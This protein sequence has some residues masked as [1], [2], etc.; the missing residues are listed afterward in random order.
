MYCLGRILVP[1]LLLLLLLLGHSRASPLDL[2]S[3][4]YAD[5]PSGELFAHLQRLIDAEQRHGGDG[6]PDAFAAVLAEN[7]YYVHHGR[8]TCHGRAQVVACLLRERHEL[9]SE[10][11]LSQQTTTLAYRGVHTAR[12][13]TD[14]RRGADQPTRYL[15]VYYTYLTEP[16]GTNSGP[17]QIALLERVA[18]TR[19]PINV[20]SLLEQ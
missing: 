1:T 9:A 11:R 2:V 7:C 18:T 15:D 16:G 17:A 14:V 5:A 8:G 20:E 19:D 6:D 13:L 3:E 10:G 12:V 4:A